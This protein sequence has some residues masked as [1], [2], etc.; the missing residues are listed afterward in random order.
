MIFCPIFC[1]SI[2]GSVSAKC[3]GLVFVKTLTKDR[4]ERENQGM[5]CVGCIALANWTQLSGLGLIFSYKST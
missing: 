4:L 3:E 5:G 2:S 1:I